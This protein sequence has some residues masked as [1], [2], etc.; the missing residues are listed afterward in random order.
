M[1]KNNSSR[2][3]LGIFV[4]VGLILLTIGIYFIGQKQ[5]LFSNTFRVRCIFKD[6]SGLQVGNNVRFSGINVG[7]VENI[8]LVADTSVRIDLVINNDVRKFIKKDAKAVIGSDGLMGN[9]IIVIM[10]GT[11]DKQPIANNDLI[12][13][14]ASV[15]FDDIMQS[16]KVTTDNAAIITEDLAAIMDN[17]SSGRG[18]IGKLFM[19]SAFATNIDQ[20][21]LNIK[22]GAGGFKRNMDAAS[23]SILLRGYLKKKEK[24]KE[25]EKEKAKEKA[26]EQEPKK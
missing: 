17:I 22:Q 1:K 6:I 20:T 13:T 5:Q 4:I 24:E 26:K 21:I 2:I 8:E 9:K 11:S 7:V 12:A 25:K 18:T 14:S 15:N 3:K 23:H 16:L 19:D 10:P